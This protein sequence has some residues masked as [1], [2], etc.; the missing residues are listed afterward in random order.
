MQ[1]QR[2]PKT[3]HAEP[4]CERQRNANIT[5]TCLYICILYADSTKPNGPIVI[6]WITISRRA[7]LSFRFVCCVDLPSD[8]YMFYLFNKFLPKRPSIVICFAIQKKRGKDLTVAQVN[9]VAVNINA[10]Y[11]PVIS[12]Y[13]SWN[14]SEHFQ[15]IS[16]T[17][18]IQNNWTNYRIWTVRCGLWC[19]RLPEEPYVHFGVCCTAYRWNLAHSKQTQLIKW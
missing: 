1:P 18:I 17:K 11:L 2:Q 12:A 15:K 8:S 4:N 6:N 7:L 10:T 16:I 3:V 9:L 13:V 19:N 5:I 14:V